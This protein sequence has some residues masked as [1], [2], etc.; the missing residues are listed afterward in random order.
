MYSAPQEFVDQLTATFDGRLRIRWSNTAH[1]FH[2]EQRVARGLVNF[3]PTGNDDELIRL[4]D[5]YFYVMSIRNG[6]RMP[7]PKCATT[8]KVPL[9]Q[10]RELS[11]PNCKGRGVEHRVSAGYFPLDSTLI[12]YL[13]MIDPMR[14]ASKEMRAK[15]DAHNDKFTAAQRQ[16]VL[17]EAVAAGHDDFNRIAGIPEFGYGGSKI[18]PGTDLKGF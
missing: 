9:R 2:I 12:D 1:E 8:L 3:P 14:G 7:C 4:R 5:G 15:I 18:L 13:K 10:I 17:D 11:C 6:D 16:K